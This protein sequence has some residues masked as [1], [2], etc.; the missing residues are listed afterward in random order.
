[1][2]FPPASI[3]LYGFFFNSIG[4]YGKLASFL[5]DGK[6]AVTSTDTKSVQYF[7]F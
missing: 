5:A 4:L 1:M 2:I 3:L 6:E 7:Y